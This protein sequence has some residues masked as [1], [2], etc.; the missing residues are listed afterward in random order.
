MTIIE[1]ILETAHS[2]FWYRETGA[3]GATPLIL[4]HAMGPDAT[5]WDAVAEALAGQFHVLALH[6]RGFGP[7]DRPGNYTFELMRD[8][9]LAFADALRLERFILVGHSMGGTVAYLV[10]E[11]SPERVLK[12]VIEDTPPPWGG[13]MPDPPEAPPEPVAFDWEAWRSIARQLKYPDPRWWDELPEIECPTLII[14]GGSSS[15]VPQDL[16]VRVANLIPDARL[17]TIEGAGHNVHT[18]RLAEFMAAING[19]LTP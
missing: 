2:R 9:V 6:Q 12:L 11:K 19:F 7:G 13:D 1:Q 17:L 4:L 15:P 3:A 10:A 5:Y 18:A 8:D 16:L 14:G